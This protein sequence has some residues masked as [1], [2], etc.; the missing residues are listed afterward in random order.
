VTVVTP[1]GG[2]TS[3]N[4]ALPSNGGTA[5]SSSRYS[6]NHPASAVIDGVRNSRSLGSGGV[7]VD[8]TGN[9]YPD[10]VQVNF[11]GVQTIDRVD[12]VTIP[13]NTTAEPTPTMTFASYG[14]TS[15]D[16]QYWTGTTW[17]TVPG[18]SVTG[19][20]MVWRTFTFTPISTDRIRVLV[21]GATTYGYSFIAEVEAWSGQ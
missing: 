20:N 7:W 21:K 3:I 19:N 12:V 13:D 16:V 18:G 4:V 11:A 8:A 10:W 9:Q 2:G 14:V 17:A 15:Y 1:G 5:T 6:V